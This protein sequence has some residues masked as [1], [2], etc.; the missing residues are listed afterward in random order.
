[1]LA[2]RLRVPLLLASKWDEQLWALDQDVA[3]NHAWVSVRGNPAALP[4]GHN[5]PTPFSIVKSSW[6]P[7]FTVT[8]FL[9]PRVFTGRAQGTPFVHANNNVS[10]TSC[11]FPK[12]G[13]L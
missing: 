5:V 2:T 12:S 4:S 8:S 9:D 13:D 6:G 3:W 11:V 1:M 7:W 10:W